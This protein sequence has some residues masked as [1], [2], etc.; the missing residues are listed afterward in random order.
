M[1]SWVDRS[2]LGNGLVGMASLD[3]GTAALV[4]ADLPSGETMASFDKPVHLPSFW[5]SCWWALRLT[6]TVVVL[7]HSFRFAAIVVASQPGRFRYDLIWRKS[8]ATGFLN[9][10]TRPLRAHEF[11]LVFSSGQATYHPQMTEGHGPIQPNSRDTVARRRSHGQ[12]YGVSGEGR[13]VSRAGATD[14]FPTSVL[15][16]GSL[17]VRDPRRTHPQQKPVELLRHLIRT[18]SDPGDLVLDPVAGSGS[19]GEAANAEGRGFI[20]WEVDP[21]VHAA[22]TGSPSPDS[23]SAPPRGRRRGSGT[24]P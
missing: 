10:K 5:A 6:G 8:I 17:G 15:D 16:F 7:A 22:A 3:R 9:A 18:Y 23:S 1:R 13:G 11:V 19:T 21:A 20:G 12:N 24:R 14:R 4:I 2:I